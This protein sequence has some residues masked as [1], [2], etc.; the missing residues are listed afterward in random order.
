MQFCLID[1]NTEENASNASQQKTFWKIHTHK[2][3][4]NRETRKYLAFVIYGIQHLPELKYFLKIFLEQNVSMCNW[5]II[6]WLIENFKHR[7]KAGR[8]EFLNFRSSKM[9]NFD[10]VQAPDKSIY[11]LMLP[12]GLLLYKDGTWVANT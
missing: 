12:Q 9:S 1:L 7:I 2:K 6:H 11:F 3:H 10:L 4:R 8:E 5:I